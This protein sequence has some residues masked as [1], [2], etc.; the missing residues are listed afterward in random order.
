MI[1]PDSRYA[2]CVLY[3]DGG[4]EFIGSREQID[5]SAQPDDHFHTAV[6]GDRVDLIAHRY[7]GRAELW[8]II[9]DYNDIFFPLEIAAGTVL[10]LPSVEQVEMRILG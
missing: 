1:G 10:R 6:E 7:L 9:C 8:W 4:E 2:G 5:I 3:V